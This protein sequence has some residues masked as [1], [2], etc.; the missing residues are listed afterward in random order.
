M[1]KLPPPD[2]IIN[3]YPYCSS[4]QQWDDITY[5]LFGKKVPMFTVQIPLLWGGRPDA[6]YLRGEEWNERSTYVT[7][8]LIEMTRFMEEHTGRKYDFDRLSEVMGYVKKAAQ[9]RIEAMDL[10]TAT[11]SPASF[12]DWI[13]SIAPVTIGGMSRS[14]QPA[15]ATWTTT[16][17][18]VSVAPAAT[19]PPWARAALWASIG[20]PPPA[21]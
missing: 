8:Q 3:A 16:P 14:I 12:F 4:G 1:R 21:T 17:T 5:R 2:M 6:G 10:C 15:P 11:P 18:S 13:V 9:L 20:P 19:T 7:N